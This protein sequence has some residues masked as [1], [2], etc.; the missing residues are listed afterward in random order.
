MFG[1]GSVV[2]IKE[3]KVTIYAADYKQDDDEFSD[4]VIAAYYSSISATSGDALKS[5]LRSLITTTHKVVTSYEDCKTDL[6][7]A[8]VDPN[9][10]TNIILFY[11]GE[12]VNATWDGGK[13]WNREHVWAQSLS[14][15]TTSKAGSDL[16]HIRPCDN[17]L[18]SSRG[19]KKFGSVTNNEYFYPYHVDGSN[20]DYRG[21]VARIIFYLLT[22]Y[23]ESDSYGFTAIAESKEL[24]LD[25]NKL[26]PVDSGEIYR[27]NYIAS[28]QGNRNPFI[29]KAE[30][31]DAIWG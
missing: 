9:D 8:D 25:W 29:D 16:H 5:Q 18:N 6:Q 14:W 30:Y 17:S 28:I 20:A 24:L 19:N 15:F 2:E 10:S 23:S 1:H 11:T 12:S 22:R 26:D 13:T 3:Y 27:N 21:D 7:Y 4:E 31:A